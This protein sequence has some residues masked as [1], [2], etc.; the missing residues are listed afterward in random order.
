MYKPTI[1]KIFK[2]REKHETGLFAK[3]D[4]TQALVQQRRMEPKRSM[5]GGF[6][7]Q[8]RQILEFGMPEMAFIYKLLERRELCRREHLWELYFKLLA[9][10]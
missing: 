2:I 1:F 4:W 8:R 5:V 7:E 6:S 3:P 10:G 9:K